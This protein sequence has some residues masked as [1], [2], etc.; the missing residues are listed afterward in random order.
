MKLPK[1]NQILEWAGA[2]FGVAGNV[3][4]AVNLSVSKWG[5]VL[6]LISNAFLIT[7]AFRQK[8]KGLGTMYVIYSIITA[9]GIYRWFMH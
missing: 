8:A 7:Y 6:F 2:L 5:F 3:L 9:V 1:I 4:V